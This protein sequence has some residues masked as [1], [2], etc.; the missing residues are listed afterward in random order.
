M[1]GLGNTLLQKRERLFTVLDIGTH[2]I[3]VLN[4]LVTGKEVEILGKGEEK[5]GLGEME[6]GAITDIA[7]VIERCHRTMREADRMSGSSP[8][9]LIF[10][11]AG[12]LIKGATSTVTYKRRDPASKIHQEE[13]K[14][15]IHKVQWKAFEK[16]R[17]D[18]AYET[19]FN[20]IDVKLVYAAIVDTRVDGYKVANPIGFQGREVTMSVFNAFSPAVH[21]GALQTISA[22]MDKELLAI[23]A[24]PYAVGRLLGGTELQGYSGVFIDVGGGATDIAVVIDGSVIGTKM[25]HLGG[26]AFTKRLSQAL[27]ISYDEADEIKIAF[28]LN[29]L[30][31]QSHSIVGRALQSDIDIWLSGV[32]FSLKELPDIDSMP[33]T[34][35]LC[36]GGSILPLIKDGLEGA[37]WYK[38]LPFPRKPQIKYLL[39]KN[40]SHIKD[41]TGTLTSPA[42]ITPIA[43]AGIGMEILTEEKTLTKMLQKVVRLM[44]V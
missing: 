13:L 10:G 32:Y 20:E 44:Q 7:G 17:G 22:E 1:F 24:E 34:V 35:Y 42:D 41:K 27:N 8:Q 33:P 15:I 39:P 43:L 30:E 19:G 40:I 18:L 3:K 21:F 2:S 29:Q 9:Q 4:C 36:G 11:I 38:N 28:S 31:H 37:D 12:E 26:H 5:Q 23:M 16:V 14:N 6:N 25:F